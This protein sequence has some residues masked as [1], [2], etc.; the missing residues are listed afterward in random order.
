M[1]FESR[2]EIDTNLF[3]IWRQ[4]LVERQEIRRSELNPADV[5]LNQP[6]EAELL[7]R[8]WFY[9]GR[10]RD[11]FVA[12]FHN[13]HKMP[14][15]KWLIMSPPP[16]IQGFLQFLPGYVLLYRPRPV[17]LQ[18]LIS[19]YSDELTD[20]YPAIVKS[21]DKESCQ[22]LMSR[23]ANANLRQLLKNA[24]LAISREQSLGWFGIEQNRLSDQVCAGLYGN[25]NQNLLKA[26][27]LVAACNR[28]RLQY[29]HGI[30][31]FLDNLA[32]AEAVFESGLVADSLAILLDAWE[33]CLENHQ[34]TD[35][36]RDIQLAKRFV[37]V[38]RRVAPL[39]V[40]LEHAPAAGAAY[41]ALYDRY[42]ACL[43]NNASTH[44]SLELMDRLLS[45]NQSV[46]AVKASL[47][48][49]HLQ[50]QDEADGE[51]EPLF[52]RSDQL[53]FRV[54]KALVDGIRLAQPQEAITLILAV[55]WLDKHND[56]S[57]DSAASHWIF[58]QCR[59]F[60][61]WVPSKMFFNAR[62]WSQIGKLLEDEN[63][64]AGDRLLSRVEELQG[65]GLQF[66]LLH[67]P[68][69]FKQRN[70]IIE[71]HILAGA[72]LGVH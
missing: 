53:E 8:A 57:L 58:T 63:R 43:P 49:W 14:I 9:S 67:R 27:D 29:L 72:F 62:I 65:D 35:I 24:A 50:I 42:F 34:L 28:N 39:Y 17:E 45:T 33:E 46:P 71:R 16:I 22:Y 36:L 18:F 26:L 52:N 56:S 37:R 32:A 5:V 48:L 64:Q 2:P 15:I 40:M 54:L 23:T 11:L 60:W 19:L 55:L 44:T 20:W 21:L 6:E 68:D 1:K 7:V 61:S 3:D 66:D 41:Q 47:K 25:K 51:Y 69:L 31:L 12:L 59:D 30:E 70:R 38:L 10:S 13:L 4:E